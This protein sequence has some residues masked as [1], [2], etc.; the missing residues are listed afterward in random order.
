MRAFSCS[1]IIPF[2]DK[3]PLVRDSKYPPPDSNE[4]KRR[5]RELYEQHFH[6]ISISSYYL[7]FPLF[8]WRDGS[9]DSIDQLSEIN[10]TELANF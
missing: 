9:I 2:F 6:Y 7:L 10:S 5:I 8:G 1:Q 3:F 4:K